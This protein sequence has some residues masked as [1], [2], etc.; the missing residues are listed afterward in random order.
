MKLRL[1]DEIEEKEKV[2][3][4]NLH[5]ESELKALKKLEKSV[6]KIDRSK[7]KLEQEFQS[8]KVLCCH[9]YQL[10]VGHLVSRLCTNTK[11]MVTFNCM[12]LFK[13]EEI[14][15]FTF[16]IPSISSL[17]YRSTLNLP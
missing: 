7:K 9:G 6:Q 11:R 14:I 16:N 8:Y 12:Y 3:E 1:Q 10:L 4:K 13:P 5:L 15:L 2:H 17:N